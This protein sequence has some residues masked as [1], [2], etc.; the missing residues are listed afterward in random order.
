MSKTS[1]AALARYSAKVWSTGLQHAR[2]HHAEHGHLRVPQDFVT[3]CGY[4]L[5]VWIA[6][7]RRDHALDRMPDDRRAELEAIGMLWRAGNHADQ[8]ALG[9]ASAQA[10]HQAHGHLNVPARYVDANGFLLGAWLCTRRQDRRR[11]IP[12]LTA[13]KQDALEA[14]GMVWRVVRRCEPIERGLAEARRYH[15]ENG[16]LNASQRHVTRSAFA[17]GMWLHNRRKDRRAGCL[18][19]TLREQLDQLGMVWEPL[20]ARSEAASFWPEASSD[21]STKAK[22]TP[23]SAAD[24][25]RGHGSNSQGRRSQ[26]GGGSEAARHEGLERFTPSSRKA[27]NNVHFLLQRGAALLAV[28]PSYV[29]LAHCGHLARIAHDGQVSWL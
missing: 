14:I 1:N 13:A 18:S 25:A 5:G 3:A 26:D 20:R 10:W 6:S 15:A 11:G 19:K 16:H 4:R 22:S 28:K 12:T 17:L 7:R 21:Q 8:W 29:S 9:L 24:T 27:Y 2:A 23:K